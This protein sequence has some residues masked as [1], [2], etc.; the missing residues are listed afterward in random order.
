VVEDGEEDNS[1]DETGRLKRTVVEHGERLYV[2][3]H[4]SYLTLD[5]EDLVVRRRRVEVHRRPLAELGLVFLQGIAMNIS[6]SLQLKLA[7]LDIPVVSPWS[8]SVRCACGDR[9]REAVDGLRDDLRRST[10]DEHELLAVHGVA[11]GNS[12]STIAVKGLPPSFIRP[13]SGTPATRERS[14]SELAA[15]QPCGLVKR[16]TCWNITR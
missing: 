10:G 16:A 5:G 8:A 11:P 13:R 6:V 3:T 1:A 12:T 9:G 2:L 7:A 14:R 4:G 15:L